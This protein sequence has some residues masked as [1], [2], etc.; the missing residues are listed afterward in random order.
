MLHQ[1]PG[2]NSRRTRSGCLTC[3]GRRRKCDEGRPSCENCRSK[4]L[5][6]RYGVKITFLQ[7]WS[8]K[9]G[10]GK[11]S[12]RVDSRDPER[13]ILDGPSTADAAVTP[14]GQ[15]PNVDRSGPYARQDA[16]ACTTALG[17][18]RVW[19]F[20]RTNS[21]DLSNFV[22]RNEQIGGAPSSQLI[23]QAG[24][25]RWCYL[26]TSERR[27]QN[28]RPCNKSPQTATNAECGCETVP[29]TCGEADLL[30][31]YRYR[32]APSLDLGAVDAFWGVAVLQHSV[33]SE[34]LRDALHGLADHVW[35]RTQPAA[36]VDKS[37]YMVSSSDP[38]T[39]RDF[40]VN[41]EIVANILETYLAILQS[42]PQ[43]WFQLIKVKGRQMR[44]LVSDQ[45]EQ[46]WERIRLAALLMAS[47][48]A[49]SHE[50]IQIIGPFSYAPAESTISREDQL[51]RAL[52]LLHRAIMLCTPSLRLSQ[53]QMPFGSL[54]QSC[55]SDAQIWYAMRSED[56]QQAL[57]L[58]DLDAVTSDCGSLDLPC[59]IFTN[60]CAALA[61]LVHHLTSLLLL[62]HKPRLTKV[63]A[64]HGS[65][66]SVTWHAV[67]VV[68]IAAVAVEDGL[69]D[70]LLAAASFKAADV[71]SHS[72]QL[73]AVANT[74][75]KTAATCGMK[76]DR[77]ISIFENAC[78]ATA[79]AG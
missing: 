41:E 4:N 2:K 12:E 3:R 51:R 47:P 66:T 17:N 28:S 31:F 67:R 78:R 16:D 52:Y 62:Q 49:L 60:A 20:E 7:P 71:L 63:A 54:W 44:P 18:I 36:V 27:L 79:I 76:L 8:A 21:F 19:Q 59:I 75:R 30:S 74:L 6:C 57:E 68:G 33:R 34:S 14:C 45:C 46:L 77:E 70:P 32:I 56:V 40:G 73:S 22:H 13:G 58:T 37:Q 10:Q 29:F 55:W 42:A 5:V 26:E 65:S 50:D 23:E 69:C 35:R 1:A 43:E 9:T 24:D 48:A 61:N 64:E 15:A 39:F 25:I 53:S 38:G 72:G 11:Q